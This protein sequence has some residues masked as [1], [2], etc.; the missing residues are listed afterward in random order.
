MQKEVL[1]PYQNFVQVAEAVPINLACVAAEM[2]SI[3]GVLYLKGPIIRKKQDMLC[4]IA[5][6]TYA[7]VIVGLGSTGEI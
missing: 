1:V 3:C 2:Q 6:C 7:C 4:A 5:Y